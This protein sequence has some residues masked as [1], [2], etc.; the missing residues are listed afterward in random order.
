MGSAVAA[1]EEAPLGAGLIN[2]A[3]THPSEFKFTSG[4]NGYV[5]NAILDACYKSAESKLWEPVKLDIWRGKTGISKDT[6][7]VEYDEDHYLLTEEMTHYGARKVVL[8][9]KQT[10]EFV[11]KILDD[12]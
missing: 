7:L 1:P 4:T 9:H 3:P 12:K 5:V 6:H 11:E 10:G 2:T 8:K